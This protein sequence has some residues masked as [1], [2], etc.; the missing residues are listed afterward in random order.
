V[1]ANNDDWSGMVGEATNANCQFISYLHAPKI[2]VVQK[3]T[4]LLVCTNS[5]SSS[6]NNIHQHA[7]EAFFGLLAI[8][9]SN[10]AGPI[11]H[12]CRHAYSAC[13]LPQWSDITVI[14]IC[15]NHMLL[16]ARVLL[17]YSAFQSAQPAV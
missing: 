4:M 14:Y 15:Y 8:G 16:R 9:I 12:S 7:A 11:S 10:T 5:S 1:A 17:L 2:F 13:W 3:V 6:N